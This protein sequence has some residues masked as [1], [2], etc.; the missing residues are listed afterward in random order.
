MSDNETYDFIIRQ[1]NGYGFLPIVKDW[2]VDDGSSGELYRG[3]FQ[4]TAIEALAKAMDFIYG[5]EEDKSITELMEEM[6]ELAD[7]IVAG[8]KRIAKE[9]G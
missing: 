1:V 7:G 5:D 8:S 6:K 4:D 9:D 3:E 2:N